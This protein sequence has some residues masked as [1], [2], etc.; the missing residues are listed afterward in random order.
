[1]F[2]VHRIWHVS[3]DLELVGK[4]K[5]ALRV[6]MVDE[7]SGDPPVS[8]DLHHLELE[9][10]HAAPKVHGHGA[11]AG[12]DVEQLELQNRVARYARSLLGRVRANGIDRSKPTAHCASAAYAA[13]TECARPGRR[14]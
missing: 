2:L 3:Q 9:P 12:E 11:D 13:M 1:M 5:C 10:T 6:P 4:G 14:R 7:D 8:V